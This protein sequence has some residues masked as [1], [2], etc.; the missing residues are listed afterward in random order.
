MVWSKE[1]HTKLLEELIPELEARQPSPDGKVNILLS[2]H[3]CQAVKVDVLD[4]IEDVGGVIVADD[5]YTGYRYFA[6]ETST[7]LPP[8]EALIEHY[9]HLAF[10]CPTRSD[11]SQDWGEFLVQSCQQ[12]G[13]QGII[14]LQPK[15]CE[16]H[17]IYYPWVRDKLSEA[18][19][20]HLYIETEHEVLSLESVKTR[21]QAFVEM[22]RKR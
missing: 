3:L 21:I 20:P 18:G 9:Y 16:T 15:H 11:E 7:S 1:E 6:T 17:M 5:L 12:S 8:F 19:I 22:I 4:M 13:A 14:M 10:P 2:G